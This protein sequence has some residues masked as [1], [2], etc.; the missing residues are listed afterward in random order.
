MAGNLQQNAAGHIERSNRPSSA[1]LLAI[2]LDCDAL[3]QEN[4]HSE[5]FLLRLTEKP[6]YSNPRAVTVINLSN[7]CLETA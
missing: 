6:L 1:L 5:I 7:R 4:L 3:L 2:Q